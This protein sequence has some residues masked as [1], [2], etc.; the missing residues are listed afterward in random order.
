MCFLVKPEFEDTIEQPLNSY[1]SYPP[2]APFTGSLPFTFIS[3]QNYKPSGHTLEFRWGGVEGGIQRDRRWVQ[4]G[5]NCTF[6]LKGTVGWNGFF[7]KSNPSCIE[8][9]DLKKFMEDHYFTEIS[10]VLYIFASP[11]HTHRFFPPILRRLCVPQTSIH[12]LYSPYTFKYFTRILRIR[13]KNEEYAE[14]F[15]FNYAWGL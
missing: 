6:Y 2:L 12:L 14:I 8:I 9:K 10:S 1:H 11:P 4:K 15:T 5:S 3:L 13:R 7:A